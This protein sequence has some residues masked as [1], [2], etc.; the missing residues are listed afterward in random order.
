MP[1]NPSVCSE[2]P[3]RSI[4]PK[5]LLSYCF[6]TFF[7]ITAIGPVAA[8]S[9]SQPDV[10]PL[11][12]AAAGYIQYRQDVTALE[13]RPFRDA[14]V[15]REAHRR[16]A[17][18][19]SQALASGFI[20]YAA[21]VAADTPEFADA[22]KS[23]L[24]RKASRR[25]SQLGGHAGL[26]SNIAQ[27][28]QFLRGLEG[29]D[30]AIANVLAC[31]ARDSARIINVGESFKSQAYA[32]QKTAWGK[33]RIAASQERIGDADEY[34]LN[35][36]APVMPG[37]GGPNDGGVTSPSLAGASTDWQTSW[38][39]TAPS[40]AM[41]NANS[42][43]I[44]DRILSL[45]ARYATGSVNEKLVSVYARDKKSERCLSLSKLT[46][47]QCI[48]ATRTPYEEAFCLGE[49]GL[50]DVATCVSWFDGEDS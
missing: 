22:L 18:H 13:A 32:M 33:K 26:M 37:L 35:R 28:A 4:F 31:V 44:M 43:A 6:A 47:N 36:S 9:L 40:G 29:T 30:R 5:P 41:H 27:D 23:E 3:A 16:L 48:A 42:H 24:K 38:G 10:S 12:A 20:A 46:L 50:N 19:D 49:H 15:T 8:E 45:A 25:Q 21:L 39:E 34:R 7:A 2:G 1:L 17:A 14:E 11:E